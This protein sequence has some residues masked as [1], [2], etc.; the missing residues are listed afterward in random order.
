MPFK[1]G[2]SWN[3]V[4]I[5]IQE[6]LESLWFN[7]Q[8]KGV[9]ASNKPLD[10]PLQLVSENLMIHI[11]NLRIKTIDNNQIPD[12]QKFLELAKDVK[13]YP[14]PFGKMMDSPV[15]KIKK[16]EVSVYW[17]HTEN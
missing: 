17:G 2:D 12:L 14:P 7:G 11:D 1:D 5:I 3:Y 9:Y 16:G 15:P 6:K 8:L 10:Y 4:E 13:K